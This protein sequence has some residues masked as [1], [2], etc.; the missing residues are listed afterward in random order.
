M[1]AEP[2]NIP[3]Y[4]LEVIKV[5]GLEGLLGAELAVLIYFYPELVPRKHS[6]TV[7]ALLMTSFGLKAQ[8]ISPVEHCNS[9]FVL[10]GFLRCVAFFVLIERKHII[11][12]FLVCC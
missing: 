7:Y 2:V 1:N 6:S 5:K 9:S 3:Y 4:G 8:V 10:K 12:A 11:S